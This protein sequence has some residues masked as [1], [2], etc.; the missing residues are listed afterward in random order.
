MEE[1]DRGPEDNGTPL[2]PFERKHVYGYLEEID[3][4]VPE[5]HV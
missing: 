3:L 4:I 1:Q 5:M 2:T